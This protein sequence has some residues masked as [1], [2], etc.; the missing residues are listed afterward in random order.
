MRDLDFASH[1]SKMINEIKKVYNPEYN[2]FPF[3][4]IVAELDANLRRISAA[5]S[6]FICV[7][8]RE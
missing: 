4:R 2:L 7:N 8:L 3:S 5:L 6:G 1:L